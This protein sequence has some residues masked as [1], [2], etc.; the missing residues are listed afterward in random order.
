[1]P[2][3]DAFLNLHVAKSLDTGDYENGPIPI[4]SSTEVNNGVVRY[5]QPLEGDR[6]FTGPCVVISGL[7]FAS[8]HTGKILPKGNGGDSCTVLF[9]KTPLTFAE[10][11]ALAAAFN[12]LHKWRFSFGRKC[13][14]TRI[15]QLELPWPLPRTDGAWPSQQ[16]I[17]D[18]CV[19]ELSEKLS[20]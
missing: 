2:K 11:M 15:E 16:R 10:Y 4:I 13:G 12:C 7:G 5:V 17:L 9:G 20:S 6:L 8:V 18:S 19:R 3:L 14:K 1:M